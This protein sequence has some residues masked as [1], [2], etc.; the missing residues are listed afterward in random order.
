M[1][2]IIWAMLWL[3]MA[4]GAAAEN[5]SLFAAGP[6]LTRA[7]VIRPPVDPPAPSGPAVP[8]LFGGQTGLFL[9]AVIAEI[10]IPQIILLPLLFLAGCAGFEPQPGPRWTR[11]ETR[12]SL[13]P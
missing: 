9:R 8:S 7:A 12:R 4:S 6:G 3:C 11:S 2:R 13:R 1:A 10:L 5:G